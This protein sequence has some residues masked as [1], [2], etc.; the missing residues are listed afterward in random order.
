MTRFD[1]AFAPR[2]TTVRGVLLNS[3]SMPA[4]LSHGVEI[5]PAPVTMADL[6]GLV[7]EEIVVTGS[8]VPGEV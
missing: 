2:S 7:S 6:R 1:P 8:R 3:T 5:V 4:L